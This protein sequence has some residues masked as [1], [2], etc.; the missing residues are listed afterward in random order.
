MLEKPTGDHQVSNDLLRSHIAAARTQ[1]QKTYQQVMRQRK[2]LKQL[3]DELAFLDAHGNRLEL[4]YEWRIWTNRD[5]GDVFTDFIWIQSNLNAQ[6][7]TGTWAIAWSY[8]E[9]QAAVA[10]TL[11]HPDGK[12]GV[13]FK[14]VMEVNLPTAHFLERAPFTVINLRSNFD[15]EGF[16]FLI[17][18][19]HGNLSSL[20]IIGDLY[21]IEEI[22]E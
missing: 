19:R 20:I 5:S 21:S 3:E 14:N 9:E 2:R 7:P 16:R 11:T 1:A 22:P 12:I 4:L 13:T 6:G 18:D 8:N 17:K 15:E 10:V